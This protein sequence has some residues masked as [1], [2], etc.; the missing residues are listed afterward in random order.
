ME[1]WVTVRKTDFQQMCLQDLSWYLGDL[2]KVPTKN[3]EEIFQSFKTLITYMFPKALL[4]S[5]FWLVAFTPGL[6]IMSEGPL[7]S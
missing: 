3:M 5:F 6:H 7:I 4:L 1:T 2:P